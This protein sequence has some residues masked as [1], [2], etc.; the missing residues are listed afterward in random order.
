MRWF[1]QP[2]PMILLASIAA[3]LFF[4][5]LITATLAFGPGREH[6][7]PPPPIRHLVEAAGPEAQP[8]FER[9][10]AKRRDEFR[11]AS[12]AMH[13]ARSDFRDLLA[14]ETLGATELGLA[15]E[16]NQAARAQLRRAMNDVYLEVLPTLSLEARKAMAERRAERRALRDKRRQERESR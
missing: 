12:E 1:D 4:V 3:N 6:G 15:L 5:G 9:A 11:A 14:A 8:A 2:R 13:S 7:P 10:M 16:A